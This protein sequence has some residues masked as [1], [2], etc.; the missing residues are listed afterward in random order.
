MLNSEQLLHFIWKN[1]LYNTDSLKTENGEMIEVLEPGLYNE[2]AGPDFFNSKIRAKGKVWAGNVEIHRASSDWVRHGHH[3]DKAYN[4]V[5]LHLAESIDTEIVNEGGRI[6]PQCRVV[7]P[8]HLSNNAEYLINSKYSLPCQNFLSSIPK[9]KINGWL[10]FLTLDR[11]ERKANDI[12]NHLNRFNNSWD[13]VF[14]VI[15]SRNYG[16][17]LNSEEF[18]RLALSLPYKYILKHSDSLFQV[19]ALMFGQAG[20]LEE[21]IEE[22]YYMRLKNE[23]KFLKTKYKLK[24]IEGY[25]FKK[26]RVRP[27]SF[28]VIRIAQLAALLQKSGRLFSTILKMK[29][30]RELFNY[31]QTE[32]SDYWQSHYSFGKSSAKN[33]KM[34]GVASLEVIVINT[35]VPMLFAYG[36][37]SGN[38]EYCTRAIDILETIKPENNIIIREFIAAGITPANAADSQA[39]IQLKREYCE[40]R[41]CL[42]CRYGHSLLSVD[43]VIR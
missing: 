11:L 31:L 20:L 9:L 6:V 38:E 30:Y 32:P 1:R 8:E 17:G 40:K 29:D 28:P 18:E 2:N 4:S 41:K 34:P 26:M 16:F 3:K 22:D 33:K 36:K 37:K 12:N 24:G 35:I 13:E 23:Y 27:V 5:I 15:L 39:I 10:S 7:V 25:V 21:V 42:Y 19:E 14:Y 43:N